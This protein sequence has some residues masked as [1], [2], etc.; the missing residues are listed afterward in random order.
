VQIAAPTVSLQ[1]GIEVVTPL[2][3]EVVPSST[4]D[5]ILDSVL[6]ETNPVQAEIFNGLENG[7]S[8]S[9]PAQVTQ[10]LCQSDT[11]ITVADV[12]I[13]GFDGA[14][15]FST[16]FGGVNATSGA[17]PANPYNLELPGLG[18]G[19]STSEYIPGTEAIPGTPAVAGTPAA[20]VI[21]AG[22]GSTAPPAVTQ[23]STAAPTSS[24]PVATTAPAT[25]PI[26]D[27]AAV[28]HGPGGPLLGIGL[29]G[30]LLLGLLAEGDRRLMRRAQHGVTFDNF[31]E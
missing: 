20:P 5:T 22:S 2:Q 29:G 9:E 21:S 18:T 3:I 28:G 12:A 27:I 13:A 11:P 24:A 1:D 23:T 4:R 19:S 6:N 31:E 7:F 17:A 25:S 26:Q 30:L 10:E 15:Y 14:G 16:S 8:P